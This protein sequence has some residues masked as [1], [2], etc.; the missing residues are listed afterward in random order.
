M[1]DFHHKVELEDYITSRNLIKS[2]EGNITEKNTLT[3]EEMN[4]FFNDIDALRDEAEVL[5]QS[6][7][8]WDRQINGIRKSTSWKITSKLRNLNNKGD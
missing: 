6:R 2:L 7:D 5:N 1:D 8:Y 3:K 4:L